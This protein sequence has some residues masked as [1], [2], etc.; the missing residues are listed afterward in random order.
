MCMSMKI[1]IYLNARQVQVI[2][3]KKNKNITWL[4]ENIGTPRRT[5]SRW[6]HKKQCLCAESREKIQKC[7]NGRGIKW[8]D[9]F[10]IVYAT[11]T[12]DKNGT[13]KDTKIIM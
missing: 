6:L 3:A 9:L 11:T 4:S 2:L 12:S 7:L 13:Y 1:R 5:I 10:T 8:G